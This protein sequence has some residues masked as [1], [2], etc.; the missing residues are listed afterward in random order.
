MLTS[1]EDT[2][3]L[4][5]VDLNGP[6]MDQSIR[7]L[8]MKRKLEYLLKEKYP[9]EKFIIWFHNYHIMKD[10]NKV[11]LQSPELK[12][13]LEPMPQMLGTIL[14]PDLKEDSYVIGLYM[15]EGKGYGY[16]IPEKTN[17][18]DLEYQLAKRG[19]SK[20]FIDLTR[21][22]SDN[23]WK[24]DKL[25]AHYDGLYPYTLVPA[26]QYDGLILIQSVSP[27]QYIR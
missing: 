6:T 1:L 20:V 21:D 12:S 19:K 13:I 14:S 2:E 26:E 7:D 11:E 18:S 25:V 10:L 24:N 3:F 22:I 8:F 27:V 17:E 16:E 15:N 4:A 9:D 5:G 23:R